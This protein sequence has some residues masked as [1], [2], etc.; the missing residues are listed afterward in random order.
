MKNEN[1]RPGQGTQKH[2]ALKNRAA[3]RSEGPSAEADEVAKVLGHVPAAS[4]PAGRVPAKWRWHYRALLSLQSRLLRERG[5]LLRVSAQPLEPHSMD[6][7]DTATDEFDHDLALTQLSADQNALYEVNDALERILD[8]R[9]G[10]CEE[11]GRTIPAAR[12]KAVPWTRFTREVEER[13]E[14][15]GA[16][17]RAGL[18]KAASVRGQGQIH[19]ASEEAEE[20]GEKP[21]ALAN[22]ET[23]A[24]VFYPKGRRVPPQKISKP[25]AAKRKGR[26]TPDS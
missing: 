23:L 8:G 1:L 12:L 6:E 22:D 13:L 16:V 20:D 21:S 10:V 7:A 2:P 4:Q 24:R 17:P 11:S 18:N 14:T 5:V 15:K 3:G 9:Y 26:N 19:L 25:R